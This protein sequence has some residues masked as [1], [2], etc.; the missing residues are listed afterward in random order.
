MA[1]LKQPASTSSMMP[2][3]LA[4]TRSCWSLPGCFPSF[5]VMIWGGV[6]GSLINHRRNACLGP[7]VGTC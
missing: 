1:N 3:T 4:C 5:W 7:L 6:F 2:I